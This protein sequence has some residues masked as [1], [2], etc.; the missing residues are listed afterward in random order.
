MSN[1][2]EKETFRDRLGTIGEEGQRLWVYPKK[3]KGKF[4]NLRRILAY[5]LTAI[6][7]L[8]PFVKYKG[9]PI[10][11]LNIFERK[12]VIM[13]VIFWPQDFYLLLMSMIALMIFVVLFTVIFG[14]LFCGWICPQTVFM[15]FLYRQ[16]EYW[17]EGSHVKQRR[18]DDQ[19]MNFEKIWK[20]TLKHIIFLLI[21]FATIN[22]FLA[23]MIGI[24]E[25]IKFYNEGITKQAG[26]FIGLIVF[27]LVH[28]FVFA[29]FREQVCIIVCPYGRLQGVLLDKNSIS[30]AYDY[31]RGEPRKGDVSAS[32]QGDCIACNNCVAV[33]PT[34]VDIRNGTQLECINCTACIDACDQVME[35]VK[36]PKGLIRY[37]SERTLA[38]GIGLK[39]NGRI[40][41]YS[42]FLTLLLILIGYLFSIR[43]DIE[44]TILRVQGTMYQEYD[45]A[46]YSNI[47]SCQVINKTRL[48]MPVELS[49][50]GGK[51]E[52][53]L[54]GNPLTVKKGE[55]GE[56]KFLVIMPK[57]EIKSSNNTITFAI[58][59][60]GKEIEEVESRFVGPNSL[61]YQ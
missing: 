6:F 60:N 29:K 8:G 36:K 18:L 48:E 20:K 5:I 28:Y 56:V 38:E 7:F 44:T 61:D 39:I 15:E 35:K 24:D 58:T 47:Y 57:S 25:V 40:I 33:C 23:Y 49:I 21:S 50:V 13:G 34:G 12:F 26:R 46:H 52:L 1:E 22:A 14:R 37:A 42:V 16:V 55:P 4:Y 41:F 53:K 10:L 59:S 17:I 54:L 45:S 3:P 43:T 19:K 11:L 32:E 30:V 51:G 2:E 31:K 27:T 9:D